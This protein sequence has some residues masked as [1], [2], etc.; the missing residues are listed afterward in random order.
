MVNRLVLVK[1]LAAVCL[2]GVLI[3]IAAPVRAA[4]D[5]L[6]A[7]NTKTHKYHCLQCQYAVKCT[8]NCITIKKSEA[9]QRGGVP[10]KICGG[11]CQRTSR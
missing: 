3:V 5:E 11:A 4:E 7:F 9:I 10:C 8:K 6:V 1:I 2:V